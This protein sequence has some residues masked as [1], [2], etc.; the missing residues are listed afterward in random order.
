MNKNVKICRIT[1]N[2]KNVTTKI[3]KGLKTDIDNK[4]NV[5]AR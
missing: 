3:L 5:K 1:A 4:T 2:T